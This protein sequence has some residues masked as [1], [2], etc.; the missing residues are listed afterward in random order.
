MVGRLV[1]GVL[2]VEVE[3]PQVVLVVQVVVGR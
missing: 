1:V 2:E 3:L